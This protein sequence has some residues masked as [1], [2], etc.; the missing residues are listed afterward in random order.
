MGVLAVAVAVVYAISHSAG[1]EDQA[2]ATAPTPQAFGSAQLQSFAA[3]RGPTK[4][5]PRSLRPGLRRA[6]NHTVRTL[7]LETAKYLPVDDGIWVVNGQ[8]ET[9]I[10]QARGGAVACVP[11]RILFQ[12]GVA[13]GVVESGPPPERK[14]REFIVYGFAPDQIK[15]VDVRVGSKK[16]LL[17]VRDNSYSLRASVPIVITG[18]DS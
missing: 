14:A 15:A 4:P 7:W 16:R 10:V 6:R 5:V 13:L 9:C 12:T 17:A 8:S 1:A 18:F 3:L 11:R 2:Q